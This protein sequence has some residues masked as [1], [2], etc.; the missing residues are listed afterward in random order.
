MS[1]SDIR[2][3]GDDSLPSLGISKFGEGPLRFSVAVDGVVAVG[4]EVMCVG[5]VQFGVMV[6]ELDYSF[7]GVFLFGAGWCEGMDFWQS[8]LYGGCSRWFFGGCLEWCHLTRPEKPHI[9]SLC[10]YF[11]HSIFVYLMFG[12][13]GLR[14]SLPR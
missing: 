12:A 10:T 7:E 13:K 4:C 14:S 8:G 2:G 9:T 11:G 6:L 5:L 3:G 1:E